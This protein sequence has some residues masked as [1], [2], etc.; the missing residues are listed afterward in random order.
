MPR[1]TMTEVWSV[2][3]DGRGELHTYYCDN[4]ESAITMACIVAEHQGFG[5]HQIE[6]VIEK[7]MHILTV[8]K[9]TL[10]IRDNLSG[11]TITIDR[12]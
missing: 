10:P 4:P 11:I 3:L 7:A 2:E 1:V 5:R 12:P 8:R 9:E 6:S